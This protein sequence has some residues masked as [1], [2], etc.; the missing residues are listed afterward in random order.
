M[1]YTGVIIPDA[2]AHRHGI[3]N[4]APKGRSPQSCRLSHAGSTYNLRLGRFVHSFGRA[5]LNRNYFSKIRFDDRIDQHL[6][7]ILVLVHIV[8]QCHKDVFAIR[9]AQNTELGTRSGIG[10]GP[11]LQQRSKVASRP[12]NLNP[13]ARMQFVDNCGIV[14]GVILGTVFEALRQDQDFSDSLVVRNTGKGIGY[15]FETVRFTRHAHKDD[16]VFIRQS[17]AEIGHGLRF[18][19][20]T[21]T[22]AYNE[23]SLLQSVVL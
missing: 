20:V 17:Q 1:G 12:Q 23:R 22:F 21:Q 6:N 13:I 19:G 15:I 10:N 3:A 8:V 14:K 11:N 18:I 7:E 9:V 16:N 2:F 5:S 4:V